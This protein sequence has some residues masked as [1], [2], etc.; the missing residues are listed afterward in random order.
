[1]WS[2]SIFFFSSKTPQVCFMIG[3]AHSSLGHFT[4]AAQMVSL[5]AWPRMEQVAFPIMPL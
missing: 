5:I 4:V 3:F 1:M 2:E